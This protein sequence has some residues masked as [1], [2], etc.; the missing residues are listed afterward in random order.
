MAFNVISSGVQQQAGDQG[1][2]EWESAGFAADMQCLAAHGRHACVVVT[3]HIPEHMPLV[4]TP[5]LQSA[6]FMHT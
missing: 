1:G 5:Q 4:H 3:D 6:A 2:G